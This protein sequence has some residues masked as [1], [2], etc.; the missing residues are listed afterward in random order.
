MKRKVSQQTW[1]RKAQ[2]WDLDYG[3]EKEF[4][5]NRFGQSLPGT[6]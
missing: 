6:F 2:M 1:S 5:S 4:F 3:S